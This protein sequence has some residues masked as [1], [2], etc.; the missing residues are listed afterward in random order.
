ML[1][2]IMHPFGMPHKSLELLVLTVLVGR[3]KTL[4]KR[5]R[6]LLTLGQVL[7]LKV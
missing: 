1:S 5:V 3:V 6:R 4:L 7:Q 2:M